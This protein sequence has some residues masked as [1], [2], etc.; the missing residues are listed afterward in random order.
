MSIAITINLPDGVAQKLGLNERER[1]RT[2]IEA[3][4]IEGYRSG[5]LSIPQIMEMLGFETRLELDALL[6]E[7]DIPLEYTIEDLEREREALDRILG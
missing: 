5:R 3:L 2:A 1:S 7:H 6:K 4:A